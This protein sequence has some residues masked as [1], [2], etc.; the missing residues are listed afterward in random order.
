MMQCLHHVVS[1]L[2]THI[3]LDKMTAI[4]QTIFSYAFSIDNNPAVVQIS[5]WRWRVDKPL[6]EIKADPI[7]WRKY[8]A[9]RGDELSAS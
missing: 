2:L 3:P 6:S 8:G 9:L 7:H 4:S 1:K 5:D